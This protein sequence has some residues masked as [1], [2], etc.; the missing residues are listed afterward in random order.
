MRIA[1]GLRA[2]LV[3]SGELFGGEHQ[4]GRSQVVAQ[5]VFG[6]RAD[7]HRG[8]ARLADQVGERHLC[9]RH[10]VRLADLDELLDRVVELVLVVHRRLVPVTEMAAAFG[11]RLNPKIDVSGELKTRIDFDPYGTD[12]IDELFTHWVPLASLINNLNRAVG[13]HDAYP[14]VLTPTVVDKLGFI[15]KTVR[16]A[17][18]V[19]WSVPGPTGPIFINRPVAH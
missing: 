2:D 11:V 13:Q 18:A 8:D 16:N 9:R 7:D 3:E 15:Q 10:P 17:G 1:Q 4:F 12:T 5:L 19:Q 14:F 6:A